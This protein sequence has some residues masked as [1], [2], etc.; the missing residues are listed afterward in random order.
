MKSQTENLLLEAIRQQDLA[1]IQTLL[2][3][4]KSLELNY[5]LLYAAQGG[6]PQIVQFLLAGGADVNYQHG[7]TRINALMLAAGANH[8]DVVKILLDAGADVNNGND[9]NSTALM[10]AAYKG[11]QEMVETLLL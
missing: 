6:N 7:N 4:G 3:Q 5:P 11:Y 9:D 10:I 1:S 8:L 2:I